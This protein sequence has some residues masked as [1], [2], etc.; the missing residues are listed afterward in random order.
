MQDG[1]TRRVPQPEKKRRDSFLERHV[2]S[3]VYASGP[4]AGSEIFLERERLSL[5]RDAQVD[6]VLEDASVSHQHAALELGPRG[7]RIRDL[8]STNGIRVNGARVSSAELKHGD[9]FALGSLEFCYVVE[10]RKAD[11]PTHSVR[12]G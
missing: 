11:P 2:V 1:R 4:L 7:F 12:E 8:G 6:L 9:R 3:L 10:P 5:G